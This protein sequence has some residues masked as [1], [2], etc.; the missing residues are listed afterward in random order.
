M[1]LA[2]PSYLFSAFRN[3]N[4]HRGSFHAT[5]HLKKVKK[6]KKNRDLLK[7]DIIYN[8]PITVHILLVLAISRSDNSK[9][10]IS[11]LNRSVQTKLN[12]LD[13][14]DYWQIQPHLHTSVCNWKKLQRKNDVV[15]CVIYR[16]WL[17][18]SQNIYSLGK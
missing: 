8:V 9:G 13:I 18:S 10:P 4:K 17:V 11:L 7:C 14:T 5:F 3:R 6:T 2:P 16:V 1:N 12:C 15:F